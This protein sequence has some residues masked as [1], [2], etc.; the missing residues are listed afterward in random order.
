MVPR[1]L[2]LGFS[3]CPNDTFLFDAWVNDRLTTAVPDVE[4]DL[5]DVEELNRR[6]VAGVADVTKLSFHAYFHVADR[7]VMLPAGAALGRGVGPLVVTREP[8]ERLHGPIATPGGL[9][10]ANLLL[11]LWR[12]EG[13]ERRELRYDRILPAVAAGDVEAG[14]II[15]ESRF[16][17]R[18][19]GLHAHVDL[20]AWWEASTDLPL[21]LG[22]IAA[23]RSLGSEALDA[24]TAALRTSLDAAWENPA[25]SEAY[26]AEHAQEIDPTVRQRHIDLYVNDFSRDLGPEGRAAIEALHGRAHAHGL[27]PAIAAPLIH[28]EHRPATPGRRPPAPAS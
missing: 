11:D 18:E 21:P 22:G 20:G 15:H 13:V 10:T 28:A 2:R 23:R 27:V 6:A 24:L 9:T 16:T 3:P 25:A 8:V 14:L 4:V 5:A 7:Y 12:P 19:H 17:Y 26:V 1:T